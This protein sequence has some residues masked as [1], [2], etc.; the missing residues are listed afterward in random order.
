MNIQNEKYFSDL[1]KSLEDVLREQERDVI[2]VICERLKTVGELNPASAKQMARMAKY[3]NADLKKIRNIIQQSTRSTTDEID[4]IFIQAAKDSKEYADVLAQTAVGIDYAGNVIQLAHAAAK[5]YKEKFLN[6]ADTYAFK[7]DGKVFTIRQ[8]YVKAV[9][10]AVVGVSTGTISY[11]NAIRQTVKEMADSGIRTI[12]WA[13]GY[14]RR[15]DSTIRMNVLEGVRQLNQEILKD[16][17]EKY[18]TGYEISA[19][20]LPAP[21]H[22]DIQGR[23]YTIAEYE[24]LNASLVRPIGTL[25]CMHITYPIVYGKSVPTYTEKQLAEMKHRAEKKY[26][27][28]GKKYSGYECTQ[29]Q[30]KYETAIRREKDRANALKAAG[31][32]LGEKQSK[33]RV[34]ELNTEYKEFSEHVGLE[35]RIDRT[36]VKG[37]NKSV[38]LQNVLNVSDHYGNGIIPTGAQFTGLRQIAGA[39]SGVVLREANRLAEIYGGESQKWV[40]IGGLVKTDN[41]QYD[42]H[43]YAYDGK[44]FES[45]IVGRKKLK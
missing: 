25:N 26:E 7:T 24:Q 1:L 20:E 13:S 21:D 19:H 42:V 40:K 27:W 34:R 45:K 43:W 4:K 9:N 39:K 2:N 31:D 6:L 12:E 10:R 29:Q 36:R 11:H 37:Y 22:A 14:T 5:Q 30:R 28:K 15:A 41:F 44:Q 17:G 16:A 32:T 23:Q 35:P 8:Q 38:T 3:M 18:A 33:R